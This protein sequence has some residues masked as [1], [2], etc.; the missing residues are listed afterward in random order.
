MRCCTDA[1]PCLSHDFGYWGLCDA[2]VIYG[3]GVAFLESMLD[4]AGPVASQPL[5][6]PD[7]SRCPPS[8]APGPV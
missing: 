5:R 4:A 7:L 2:V 8:A 1:D 6:L 3:H